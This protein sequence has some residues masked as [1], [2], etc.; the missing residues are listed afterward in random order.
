MTGD[1]TEF[2]M[3]PVEILHGAI[4]D[5][6]KK[7]KLRE[8]APCQKGCSW[9][10]YLRVDC[11]PEEGELVA[12]YIKGLPRDL[13]R[14]LKKA[15]RKWL[16]VHGKDLDFSR[17]LK[18]LAA[19]EIDPEVVEELVADL[20]QEHSDRARARNSPCP[21]LVDNVCAIYPVRPVPCRDCFPAPGAT[22][23][24]CE[25]R[26][27]PLTSFEFGQVAAGCNKLGIN[28]LDQARLPD[29]VRRARENHNC[30]SREGQAQQGSRSHT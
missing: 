15:E 25:D 12:E 3:T 8:G 24:E 19:G 28:Y 16:K 30:E 5:Q 21:Y 2:G 22:A 27:A 13:R 29:Q 1:P 26:T 17:Y 23:K 18:L 4:D 6:V 14:R 20:S 9:C 10:C 7:K 11:C